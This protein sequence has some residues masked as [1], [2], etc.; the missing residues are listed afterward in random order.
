MLSNFKETGGNHA[1]GDAYV[2]SSKTLK[3]YNILHDNARPHV[4]QTVPD[5]FDSMDWGL[6]QYPPY[7]PDLSQCDFSVFYPLKEDVEFHH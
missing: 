2:S 5:L 3:W 7:T 1:E 6:L 4:P